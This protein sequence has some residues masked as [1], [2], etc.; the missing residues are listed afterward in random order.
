MDENKSVES[1]LEKLLSFRPSIEDMKL[2]I[3]PMCYL[4]NYSTRLLTYGESLQRDR[5]RINLQRQ[6]IK[7]FLDKYSNSPHH[8]S[9][10]MKEKSTPS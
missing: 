2:I 8:S 10:T 9:Q 3:E 4:S 5:Y 7:Y 1:S 6:L